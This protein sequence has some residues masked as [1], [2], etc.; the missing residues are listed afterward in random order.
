MQWKEGYPLDFKEALKTPSE[1]EIS[2]LVSRSSQAP[3][4]VYGAL[5]LPTVLKYFVS[6]PQH[7]KVDM[8]PATLRGFKLYK[9]AEGG[10]PTI[11]RSKEE[12]SEVEGMLIFGLDDEQRN[13]I[14]ELEGRG[15]LT[16]FTAVQVQ[17]YQKDVVGRY[18]VKDTR[19]VDAGTFIW[20]DHTTNMLTAV[21]AS[22]WDLDDFLAGQFY[23]N[24]VK[25]QKKSQEFDDLD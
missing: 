25:I 3:R 13:S 7:V 17:I 22:C 14:F 1:A 18:Q 4:F 6:L 5:M 23:E 11:V 20:S 15:G 21:A 16:E 8:V 19:T 24:I 10:L 9:I 2:R 12:T